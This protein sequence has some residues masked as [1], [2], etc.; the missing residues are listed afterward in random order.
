MSH[1]ISIGR[2][3][4]GIDDWEGMRCTSIY[5]ESGMDGARLLRC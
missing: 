3:G 5:K 2:K 4:E 1:S